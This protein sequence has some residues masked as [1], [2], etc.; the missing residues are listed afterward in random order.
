MASA[1]ASAPPRGPPGSLG[2]VSEAGQRPRARSP[3]VERLAHGVE[4]WHRQLQHVHEGEC[5]RGRGSRPFSAGSA[6]VQACVRVR[7]V[8][9]REHAGGHWRR[10]GL[11]RARRARRGGRTHARWTA[12]PPRALRAAPPPPRLRRPP[13]PAG[14]A[15]RPPADSTPPPQTR[16]ALQPHPPFSCSPAVVLDLWR[17]RNAVVLDPLF[18]TA[19][20]E[21][22]KRALQ[23]RDSSARRRSSARAAHEHRST[24]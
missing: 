8:L 17:R 13:A 11:R 4:G 7:H 20:N 12:P 19:V 1:P 9:Q 24:V 6:G 16:R 3:V 14:A 21:H 5:V 18:V 23:A 2:R 10:E 15:W 22:A